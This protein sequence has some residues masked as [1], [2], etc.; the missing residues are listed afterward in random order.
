MGSQNSMPLLSTLFFPVGT[1]AT[2]VCRTIGSTL[3]LPTSGACA[4]PHAKGA[5]EVASHDALG[6]ICVEDGAG[7]LLRGLP[8]MYVTMSTTAVKA[9]FM[10][11]VLRSSAVA[12]E[13]QLE[14]GLLAFCVLNETQVMCAMRGS[15]EDFRR[16]FPAKASEIFP[17]S[18]E[19]ASGLSQ[20]QLDE[21]N[22]RL[23]SCY[24]EHG[25][26]V[27]IMRADGFAFQV[28]V[29]NAREYAAH[30]AEYDGQQ[31]AKT[32]RF[33]SSVPIV[34]EDAVWS[35]EPELGAGPVAAAADEE[36]KAVVVPVALVV[37]GSPVVAAEECKPGCLP[38]VR[39][40][41]LDLPTSPR[42]RRKFD[43]EVDAMVRRIT[44]RR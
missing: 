26:G 21:V 15:F 13:Q 40:F 43:A 35:P 20:T 25:V 41:A 12:L 29:P 22:R 42:K 14:R 3:P 10:F 17:A 6:R 30:Q 19:T 8:P 37:P 31:A 27:L 44:G 11:G 38:V 36:T 2:Q 7:R 16:A 24:R 28:L 18:V 1:G 5:A 32:L 39:S 34:G 23:C 4:M 33:A 9:D